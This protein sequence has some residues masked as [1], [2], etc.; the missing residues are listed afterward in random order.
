M[1]GFVGMALGA[2]APL[3]P[4][5][6]PAT[7]SKMVENQFLVARRLDQADNHPW[8]FDGKDGS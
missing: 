1:F 8:P 3:M 7:C 5:M 2:S 4:L 6:S